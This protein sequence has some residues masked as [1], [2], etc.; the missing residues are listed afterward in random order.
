MDCDPCGKKAKKA[1]EDY[2]WGGGPAEA[3]GPDYDWSRVL[4]DDG[5]PETYDQETQQLKH[6]TP[7]DEYTEEQKVAEA[8]K[9]VK[10][11]VYWTD[12]YTCVFKEAHVKLM[13][14]ALAKLPTDEPWI[15]FDLETND[16]GHRSYPA[17][18][19]I[20]DHKNGTTCLIE[21]RCSAGPG[22]GH[23]GP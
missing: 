18:M 9:N 21:Y 15:S 7:F 22:L 5:V 16:L 2:D 1:L 20:R 6:E 13:V 8:R 11:E 10:R 23:C 3:P 4:G 14:Q 12:D 17:L 19:Q